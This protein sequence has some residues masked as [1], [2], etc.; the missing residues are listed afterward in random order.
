MAAEH[1]VAAE[2]LA[3][4]HQC[5]DEI[6]QVLSQSVL[7]ED[8][9]SSYVR[10]NA[11]FHALL[12]RLSGSSV[13][14]RELER[15]LDSLHPREAGVIRS[16]FGLGDGVQKTLDQIGE[17]FGVTRERIRQIESK[18]MSKLRHPSRSQMLRDYLEN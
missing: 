10:L 13:L 1:G 2:D 4:A 12:A 15:I 7:N 18:T 5:L 6:D 3:Q 16:R 14:Q 8:A 17:E 11:Q 9:F